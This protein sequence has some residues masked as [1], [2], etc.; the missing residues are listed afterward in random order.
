MGTRIH[1]LN[2]DI[3]CLPETLDTPSLDSPGY[4][5]ADVGVYEGRE[6]CGYGL[7]VFKTNAQMM[8]GAHEQRG[9]FIYFSSYKCRRWDHCIGKVI[10]GIKSLSRVILLY[11]NV[12]VHH[13]LRTR[14]AIRR[15]FPDTGSTALAYHP[16]QVRRR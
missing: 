6:N 2:S 8:D 3:S 16:P 13:S 11:N 12:F 4:A 7:C 9:F 5:R 10:V 15:L 1:E 14:L